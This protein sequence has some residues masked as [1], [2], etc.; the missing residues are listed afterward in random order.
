MKGLRG[1]S[2][3]AISGMLIGNIVNLRL[4]WGQTVDPINSGSLYMPLYHRTPSLERNEG[5]L[6]CI[7][8][9]GS[10]ECRYCKQKH[11][12]ASD[13]LS[14]HQCAGVLGQSKLRTAHLLFC[15]SARSA[16]LGRRMLLQGRPG[17]SNVSKHARHWIRL[18][19]DAV[20]CSRLSDYT[21]PLSAFSQGEL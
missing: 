2:E 18:H 12:A 3:R 15:E 1:A 20:R 14:N 10:I 19:D 9:M 6:Q 7:E 21:A 16:D 4:R 13:H 11:H 5:E 8:K 17:L